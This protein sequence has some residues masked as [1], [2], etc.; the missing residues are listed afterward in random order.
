MATRARVVRMEQPATTGGNALLVLVGLS[1]AFLL[2]VASAR[3][4]QGRRQPVQRKQSAVCRAHL[5]RRRGRALHGFRRYRHGALREVRLHRHG[6][7]TARQHAGGRASLVSVRTSA[8]RQH[9]RDAAELCLDSRSADADRRKEIRREDHWQHH[10][11]AGRR[12]RHPD[13]TAA[14]RSSAAGSGAAIHL[15]ARSRHAG[16]VGLRSLRRELR[17]GHDVPHHRTISRTERFLAWTSATVSAIYV[18]IVA[19]RFEKWG[20]LSVTAWDASTKSDMFLGRGMRLF[21]TVPDLGWL[22]VIAALAAVASPGALFRRPLEERRFVLRHR[23][24]GGLHQ[25]SVADCCPGCVRSSRARRQL[26]V[27]RPGWTLPDQPGR[28]PLLTWRDG[29]GYF[30]FPA[31]PDAAVEARSTCKPCCPRPTRSIASPTRRFASLFR[32]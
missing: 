26:P 2:I 11:A 14:L 27:T 17:P 10:H 24:Q 23:Q 16:H 12:L 18:A 25:H 15:A 6:N 31:V 13:A 3:R 7:R 32:C 19:T 4:R 9:L 30:C 5:L 28:Q 21:V 22:F 20:G 1:V 8:V 29:D